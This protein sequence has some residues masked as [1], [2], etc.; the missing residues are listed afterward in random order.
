MKNDKKA[1]ILLQDNS[2][3]IY[4][5]KELERNNIQDFIINEYFTKQLEK[6]IDEYEKAAIETNWIDSYSDFIIEGYSRDD[7]EY[8]DYK[9]LEEN[10][11][12]EII[13][14]IAQYYIEKYFDNDM[15]LLDDM[16]KYVKLCLQ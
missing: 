11:T 14:D 4:I 7:I 10:L 9:E 6:Q 13:T 16:E 12:S 15:D 1:K 8:S 2:F 3:Q 5:N